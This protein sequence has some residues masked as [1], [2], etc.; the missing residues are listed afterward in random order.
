MAIPETSHIPSRPR[1]RSTFAAYF[2]ASVRNSARYERAAAIALARSSVVS[3]MCLFPQRGD[4]GTKTGTVRQGRRTS[5]FAY[6][7]KSGSSTRHP[8][9]SDLGN[10]HRFG[11]RARDAGESPTAVCTADIRALARSLR[12]GLQARMYQIWICYRKA[13][14]RGSSEIAARSPG[15]VVVGAVVAV[16]AP[17]SPRAFPVIYIQRRRSGMAL[18]YP[19]EPSREIGYQREGRLWGIKSGSRCEG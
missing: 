6:T 19:T 14:A 16:V 15:M 3:A 5:A 13:S 8:D 7:P 12:S 10:R 1:A 4:H 2:A 17:T 18:V 9:G 11:G